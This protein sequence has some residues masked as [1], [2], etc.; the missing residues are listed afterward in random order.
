MMRLGILARVVLILGLAFFVIQSIAFGVYYL[1][2]DSRPGELMTRAPDRI[3]ALVELFDNAPPDMR[4]P[5][6][7]AI[8]APDLSA[9]IVSGLEERDAEGR[10]MP[11]AENLIASRFEAAGL[12]DRALQVFLVPTGLLGSRGAVQVYAE[13]ASGEFLSLTLSDRITVRLLGVPVGFLFGLAGLI[14]AGAALFAIAK[15]VRPLIDLA[16]TVDEVGRRQTVIPLKERGAREIRQLIAAVNAMQ[17][18]IDQLIRGRTQMLAAISHDLGTYLTRL[19]LRVEMLPAGPA[20]ESVVADVE[21][22]RLLLDETLDFAL[23]ATSVIDDAGCD[24][25]TV[26]EGWQN[27]PDSA[28]RLT[29]RQPKAT[30]HVALSQTAMARVIGNLI[31]NALRYAD[32]A[33]VTIER[34]G[35]EA[36]IHVRDNGPG[37]PADA[38]ERVF[39]PFYRLENSRNRESGGTGLGLTI[40][41]QIIEAGN[42]T[43]AL[44][45]AAGGGLWVTVTVPALKR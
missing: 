30:V 3:V 43:I 21:S 16:N 37:I 22:M 39:E 1:T 36:V 15:Q 42:G 4:A 26:L 38:R 19:R 8:N 23:A 40:V 24:L 20:R 35:A 13:L 44:D 34:A 2:R 10:P 33:E 12:D 32:S 45:D 7:N 28:G 18:R 41:K 31:A 25:A 5:A 17:H 27:A 14:V 11:R 6:L 9:R 29:I